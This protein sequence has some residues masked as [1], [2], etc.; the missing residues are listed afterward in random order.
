MARS[1]STVTIDGRLIGEAAAPYIVAE[2]SGNHK[3]CIEHALA[4][5]EAAAACG[6]DAI[7]IQTYR[8][9]TITID[10]DGP[11]FRIEGGLWKGRTLYDLYEEAHTPWEW[12][13]ALFEKA[14]SIGITLFSSP[15][16]AAAIDLLEELGCPAYK[17]ASYEMVDVNLIRRAAAT[18][19][20]L[21]ISTGL[22]N[23]SEI[24]EA[25][26]AALEGKGGVAL[27]YCISGYPTPPEEANLRTMVDMA[28]R[29]DVPLGLSD[30][31]IG[32]DVAVAAVA[33]GAAI[34]EKHFTLARADGG[35]DS[36]F[37]LEP[38]EFK[39]LVASC[40]TVQKALGAVSYDSKP[41]EI[42]GRSFRRSLYVVA[43][44]ARGEAFTRANVRSIRPGLGLHTRYLDQ[45]VGG[46]TAET[47]IKRGT[48]LS[49]DL[50]VGGFG[51]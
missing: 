18:G 1:K 45:L 22:A 26:A 4:L 17:I 37:S 24:E 16:D 10:H 51:E 7:K 28:E 36:A 33:L 31:T 25:L 27:L 41:S 32:N 11:E 47:A 44:I 42:G 2:L 23:F 12:H 38:T 13:K 43:D 5:M 9:D 34:I 48:A 3:G 21:I 6:V 29:F 20:P 50:V 40:C 19:K 49:W 39:D 35:V 15:F 14:K 8:A 30:H 46:R